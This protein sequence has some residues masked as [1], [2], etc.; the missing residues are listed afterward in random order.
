MLLLG[1]EHRQLEAGCAQAGKQAASAGWSLAMAPAAPTSAGG[2]L[3]T[4]AGSLVAVPW[5]IAMQCANGV[6]GPD[7]SPLSSYGRVAATCCRLCKGR[8][9]TMVSVYMWHTEG[10]SPR[11]IRLAQDVS[12]YLPSLRDGLWVVGGGFNMSPTQPLAT[13]GGS[14]P[15]NVGTCR[16]GAAWFEYDYFV[17]SQ[18]MVPMIDKIKVLAEAGTSARN[19][20]SVVSQD[21]DTNSWSE[22]ASSLEKALLVHWQLAV[23]MDGRSLCHRRARYTGG[24]EAA[25]MDDEGRAPRGYRSAVSRLVPRLGGAGRDACKSG[26]HTPFD[27]YTAS[28]NSRPRSV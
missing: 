3:G 13:S 2:V 1:Q 22:I 21:E 23:A 19:T 4:S 5:S 10:W 26:G 24:S 14:D 11:N 6:E 15:P 7:L 9:V 16:S 27:T 25:E 17:V 18:G 28:P 8:L 12:W 20:R